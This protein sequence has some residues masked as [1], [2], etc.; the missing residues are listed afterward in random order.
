MT[1]WLWSL[2]GKEKNQWSQGFSWIY[3]IK[4][5]SPMC[6]KSIPVNK[7]CKVSVFIFHHYYLTE[8]WNISAV[9]ILTLFGAA[10]SYVPL[11]FPRSSLL[12]CGI[13]F[14]LFSL[15]SVNLYLPYGRHYCQE[16]SRGSM[17]NSESSERS[18]W[19]FLRKTCFFLSLSRKIWISFSVR[20]VVVSLRVTKQTQHERVC[21]N[22]RKP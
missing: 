17:T 8:I 12:F 4:K 2:P 9:I 22:S 14:H 5:K 16:T 18:D 11:Q 13:I 1:R 10:F 19:D 7:S 6:E 20:V 15:F 21:R 3:K